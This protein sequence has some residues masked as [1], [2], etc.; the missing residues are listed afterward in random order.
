MREM[1]PPLALFGAAIGDQIPEGKMKIPI[2]ILSVKKLL[3]IQV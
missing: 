3:N 1:C 2:F